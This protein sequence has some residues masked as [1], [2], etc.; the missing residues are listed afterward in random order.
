MPITAKS[1]YLVLSESVTGLKKE[2]NWLSETSEVAC[3]ILPLNFEAP[4]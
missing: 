2:F 3:Q 4:F 1:T